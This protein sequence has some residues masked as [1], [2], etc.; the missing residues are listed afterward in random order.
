MK[1]TYPKIKDDRGP[2]RAE[3]TGRG[4]NWVGPTPRTRCIVSGRKVQNMAW[5]RSKSMVFRARQSRPVVSK[6]KFSVLGR[7]LL[8]LVVLFPKQIRPCPAHDF[9][10][11]PDRVFSY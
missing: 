6:A 3:P 2:G 7:V 4:A 5:A 1:K 8:C 11:V 9:V 10:P